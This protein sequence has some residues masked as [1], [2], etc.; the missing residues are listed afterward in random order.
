[1]F[2]CKKREEATEFLLWQKRFLLKW[3]TLS[4]HKDTK[5]TKD[6]K[7][8]LNCYSGRLHCLTTRDTRGRISSAQV[9]WHSV[10][11]LAPASKK[12]NSTAFTP[13]RGRQ[14]GELHSST[15]HK[16]VARK[17]PQR[18]FYGLYYEGC[19]L[20]LF[21]WQQWIKINTQ[22]QNGHFCEVTFWSFR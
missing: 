6:N 4:F 14:R 7:G 10:L 3:I 21:A 1:M 16:Q 15:G 13:E 12:L 2:I 11:S 18:I 19:N 22:N 17:H 20:C 9:Q 8:H 5:A